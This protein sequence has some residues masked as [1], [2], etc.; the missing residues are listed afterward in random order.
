MDLEWSEE[1]EGIW[2]WNTHV[3]TC[4][5]EIH[6]EHMAARI[7]SATVYVKNLRLSV[8][9]VYAPT[10]ATESESTKIHSIQR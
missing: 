10:H 1:E 4:A 5:S 8:T 7:I 9:N 6:K 3:S 2:S